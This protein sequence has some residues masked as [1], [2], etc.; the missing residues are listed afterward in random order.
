MPGVGARALA[1]CVALGVATLGLEARASPFAVD[2]RIALTDGDGDVEAEGDDGDSDEAREAYAAGSDAYALGNYEEAVA[3]FEKAYH[4]SKRPELLFNLGQ[5][6]TRWY[7]LD[8]DVEHLHKARRLYENYVINI[9][10]AQLDEQAEAQARADAQRRIVEV[11]RL[12]AQHEGRDGDKDDRP[13]VKK[14]WFWAAV[15]G[16]AVLVAGGVTAAVVLTRPPSFEPELGTI[17]SGR[18]GIQGPPG[19][20]VF[21]F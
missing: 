11:D 8:N 15:V 18:A 5:A 12:I 7:D 17:G 19:G 14:G 9:G 1:L 2:A 20:L 13:L 4:L 10:A 16:G 6:Y 21:H 3:Q